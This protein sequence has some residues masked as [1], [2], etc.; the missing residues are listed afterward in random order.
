MSIGDEQDDMVTINSM[1]GP[2]AQSWGRDLLTLVPGE[3]AQ[4]VVRKNNGDEVVF[5]IRREADQ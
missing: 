1:D 4:I 3:E 5:S 2:N